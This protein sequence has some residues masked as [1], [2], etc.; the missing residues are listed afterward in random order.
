M[1]EKGNIVKIYAQGLLLAL[2]EVNTCGQEIVLEN[3]AR[4]IIKNGHA[5]LLS[6]IEKEYELIAKDLPKTSL[7]SK[8]NQEFVEKL[9]EF[10][11]KSPDA[12]KKAGKSGGIVFQYDE[13]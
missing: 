4:E 11:K 13:E 6:E 10:A 7:N 5:H 2:M 12:W 8:E 3:F 1:R 9:N